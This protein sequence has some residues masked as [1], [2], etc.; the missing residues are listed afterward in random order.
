MNEKHIPFS[1][2]VITEPITGEVA[3]KVIYNIEHPTIDKAMLKKCKELS[4][5]IQSKDK[6]WNELYKLGEQFNKELGLSKEE[7]YKSLSKMSPP[8]SIS[9]EELLEGLKQSGK[10]LK[11]L[12]NIAPKDIEKAIKEL[13][14][15]WED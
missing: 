8:D 9:D 15:E 12:L 5:N 11:E 4:K 1:M 13:R 10:R 14:Q 6:D 2:G 7:I 3:K